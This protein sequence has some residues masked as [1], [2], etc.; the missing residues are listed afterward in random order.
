VRGR[1]SL[2]ELLQSKFS[3][4]PAKHDTPPP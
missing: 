3:L 1:D 2:I 4:D